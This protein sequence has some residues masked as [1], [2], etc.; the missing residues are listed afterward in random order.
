MLQVEK[1]QQL[2]DDPEA[3]A[4]MNLRDLAISYGVYTDKFLLATEGNRMVIEHK[5]GAPSIEDA[6]K[7]IEE[8]RRKMRN[9]SVETVVTEVKSDENQEAKG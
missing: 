1:M 2:A 6:K 9:M 3:L 4:K 8:A 5:Q 7:A